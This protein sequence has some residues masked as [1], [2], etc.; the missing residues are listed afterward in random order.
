MCNEKGKAI[1]KLVVD[2]ER[3]VNEGGLRRANLRL[4]KSWRQI[5]ICTIINQGWPQRGAVRIR[6]LVPQDAEKLVAFD[7]PT[8][9]LSRL[10][11]FVMTTNTRAIA[12][13]E[14]LGFRFEGERRRAYVINGACVDDHLMGYVFE[15]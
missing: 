7:A 4:T 5:N 10:E 1:C 15:A 14:H 12:L 8:V 13:Y 3:A 11:L 9:G 2:G 6:G